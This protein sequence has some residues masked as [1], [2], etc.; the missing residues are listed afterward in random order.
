[1]AIIVGVSFQNYNAILS[2]IML[3]TNHELYDI[4]GGKQAFTKHAKGGQIH[5]HIKI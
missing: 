5:L 3:V 1:M 4:L 2:E